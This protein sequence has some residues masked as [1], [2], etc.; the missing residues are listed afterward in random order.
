MQDG[1]AETGVSVAFTV[2]AMDAGPI[3]A[4]R[5]VQVDPSIQAP[6][7]LQQLFDQGTEILLENLPEVWSGRGAEMARPQV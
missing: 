4:Q 3:L 5:R 6:Q 2:R 1:V 7:L